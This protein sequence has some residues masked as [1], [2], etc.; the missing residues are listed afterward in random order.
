MKTFFIFLKTAG[1]KFQRALR[2]HPLIYAFVGGVGI[3]LFWRGVWYLTDFLVFAILVP[4]SQVTTID[5][6]GGIDGGI[7]LV[8]GVVL[9]LSTGLFVSEFLSGQVLMAEGRE[10]E[11]LAKET[12]EDVKKESSELP[13]IEEGL[14]HIEE[15]IKNLKNQAR[16]K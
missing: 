16:R 1:K 8:L 11:K 7:S 10:E 13:S 4:R 9:L 15:E 3:V 12:E 2:R 6:T 14:Q 5:W